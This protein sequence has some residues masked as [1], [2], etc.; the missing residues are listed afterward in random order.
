M[1]IDTLFKNMLYKK[2]IEIE[3]TKINLVSDINTGNSN[4]NE[5]EKSNNKKIL[6][7]GKIIDNNGILENK[8]SLENFIIKERNHVKQYIKNNPLF[9]KTLKPYKIKKDENIDEIPEIIKL[10]VNGSKIA[11]VGPTATLAGTIAELSLDYLV[12]KGS[13][14]SIIDNGGDI[15]FLNNYNKEK[16]I[17]GIYAGKSPLSG[18]IGFEFDFKK[19]NQKFGVCSSSGSVGY[20]LSYGRSDSVTIISNQ[21]SISDGLATSIG[22]EVNGKKDEDAVENGLI[23]AEKFKEHYTGALIIVGESVGTIGKLPKIVETENK[24]N[25]NDFEGE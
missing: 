16:V 14:Y 5:K 13:N 8:E 1:S 7:N 24:M 9:A 25:L 21:A 18:K 19:K 2:R 6:D 3:E 12:E 11:N 20:S 10:M 15:A 17:F 22:N 23:A 4:Y